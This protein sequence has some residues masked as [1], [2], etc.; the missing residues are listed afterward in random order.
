MTLSPVSTPAETDRLAR[1]RELVILDSAPEPVFDSIARMASDICGVPIALISLIDME[2]QWFKANVGLPGVN[3]TPRDVAFCDYAIRSGAVLEVPDAEADSRFANNP[4]VTGAPD[5]RF[6]AGAPLILPGGQR[7]GTLCVIDR[8]PRRLTDA[9]TATLR[10]LAAIATQTLIMRRD[11]IDR[12]LGVRTEQDRA[13][14]QLT[15]IIDNTTD[16][17]SQTDS[18]GNIVYLNPAARRSAGIALD[19]PLNESWYTQFN[20]PETLQLYYEVILPTLKTTDVWVGETTVYAEHK[21]EIPVSHM[22]IA[23]RD[24]A[25]KIERYSTVMRDISVEVSAKRELLRQTS[26]LLSVT[27]AIADI[28]AVFDADLYYR[29][30]NSA[31]ERWIAAPRERI[32]GQPMLKVLGREAFDRIL[33]SVQ[34]ALAGEAVT[35]E[36][37]TRR[38]GGVAYRAISF[39]PLRM[40]DG[41]IDS[42]VAVAQDVTAQ[43][44]EEMRLRELSQ[45][46]PLTGL[47]NRAGFEQYLERVLGEGRGPSLALLY[48][49][50]DHFKPINDQYGHPVGDRV[51]QLFAQRLR[52]TVR[53]TDGV[54]RLGG[55]EFAV[56]LTGVKDPTNAHAVAEKVITSTINP[57]AVGDIQ[58]TVSAS[59][60]VSFGAYAA[61]GW[62]DLVARA[63]AS[64]YKAKAAGRGRYAGESADQA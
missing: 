44:R 45:R 5:I 30:V 62:A 64:L 19:A 4:L 14:R 42:V 55:D 2:R 28:V 61:G 22:V 33:P 37:T 47:L 9:Q 36:S 27:E 11:L 25:G 51:L 56:V 15:A 46:D 40:D 54:A 48:I 16:F 7:I 63:D 57:F 39:T 29:F 1:L 59:V 23:H 34:K 52:N 24:G 60:G 20:P 35:Y 12:T 3:E 32:I 18:R 17:V 21:R 10:S 31:F 38:D 26:I 53:P 8:Q 50:L 43:K 13:V 41:S 6:Y 49:D 58:L